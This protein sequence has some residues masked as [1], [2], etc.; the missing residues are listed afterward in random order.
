MSHWDSVAGKIVRWPTRPA[1]KD[2]WVEIDC[3]CCAGI[4]WG[5]DSPREC[6]RC[7]DGVLCVHVASGR[8]AE[9]PGGPLMGRM[10]ADDLK[11]ALAEA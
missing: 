8:I 6:S 11:R 3:G 9:Y 10:H 1:G 4:E 5:G 7:M 2:G